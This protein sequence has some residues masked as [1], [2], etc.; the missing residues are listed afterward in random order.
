MK[1]SDSY[2]AI[3][4]F[5]RGY[6]YGKLGKYEKARSDYTKVIEL[7]PEYATAYYYRGICYRKLG[8][9]DRAISDYTKAIELDPKY[10]KAYLNR[11]LLLWWIR[12]FCLS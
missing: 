3:A 1:K 2:D 5:N 9:Y 8:E 12:R 10:T 4:Y 6:D 11:A 7:N